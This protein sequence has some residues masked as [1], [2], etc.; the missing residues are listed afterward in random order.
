M[1][2]GVFC[3]V[4]YWLFLRNDV[5]AYFVVLWFNFRRQ[6]PKQHSVE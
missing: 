3:L 6:Y 2:H 4:D 5:R 1:K